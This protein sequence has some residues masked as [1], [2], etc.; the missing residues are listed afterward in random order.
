MPFFRKTLVA[1]GVVLAFSGAIV[2]LASNLAIE[3]EPDFETVATEEFPNKLDVSGYFYQGDK[4]MLYFPRPNPEFFRDSYI[5]IPVE[6]TDPNG[7]EAEFEVVFERV[8]GS[9]YPLSCSQIKLVKNNSL[10]VNNPPDVVG[11]EVS[12]PGLYKG[13]VKVDPQKVSWYWTG[14]TKEIELAKEVVKKEYPYRSILPIG[15]VLIILGASV[16]ILAAKSAERKPQS[17]RKK[18]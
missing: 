11:G 5:S 1:F 6:I 9:Q 4:L 7:D 13:H 8:G 12:Y 16:S 2:A 18:S 3:S 15:I 14:P 10:I 17:R